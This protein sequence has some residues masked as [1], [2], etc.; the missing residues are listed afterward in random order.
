MT[1]VCLLVVLAV[2]LGFSFA[3]SPR[4]EVMLNRPDIVGLT[5]G[6]NTK[7]DGVVTTGLSVGTIVL[8]YDE[9]SGET[10]IYRLSDTTG[11]VSDSIP[12]VIVPDDYNA[13]T[14][15]KV[16]KLSISSDAGGTGS[17]DTIS[18]GSGDTTDTIVVA[19]QLKIYGE[20]IAD[21]IQAVG[22]TILVTDNMLISGGNRYY[23]VD[24]TGADSFWIYDDG[25]T[26]RFDSDNPI[27]V[28]HSSLVVDTTGDVDIDGD[29]DI[30]GDIDVD[31]TS[32]FGGDVNI[33][34]NLTVTGHIIETGSKISVD[35]VLSGDKDITTDTLVLYDQF[36]VYG[37]LIADSIQAV[38][39]TIL[40]TDNMLISGGNRYYGVDATGADSFWI[41]DDG[42]TTRFDSDN[43]IKIGHGSVVSGN[44]T[45]MSGN[46]FV[47]DTLIIGDVKEDST[48]DSILV[49]SSDGRVS[50]A[51]KS[52]FSGGAGGCIQNQYSS[53]QNAN[54]WISGRLSAAILRAVPNAPDTFTPQTG[55]IRT[56][57]NG[58][59]FR[60]YIYD[61][62]HWRMW[63]PVI[64]TS[65]CYGGTLSVDAGDDTTI[66]NG[67]S[68]SLTAVVSG[69]WAP[70][71]YDWDN[72]GTSDWDDPQTITVSPT[73]TTLYHIRVRDITS[74]VASDS[75]TVNVVPCCA[76]AIGG[77]NSD[78]GWSVVQT[79]DGGFVVAGYTR[80][81]GAGSS[82]LF[83]VKFNSS[84]SVQWAKAV[85]GTND[86]YGYSV[87]QTSDSGLVVAGYTESFGAGYD[88]LFLVKFN[89]SGSVQWAKAV[90][91]TGYDYGYSVVQTSDSGFVVAGYTY[92]FG[93]GSGDLFL[94]KF[95]SSGS[96]QWAKA[97]GGTGWDY[98]HSVI[99]T[100]DSGL[101]VV[102]LT[103][104]YGVLYHAI[105]CDLF[106]VKFNSSG[107]VQWAK[108]VGG[109]NLDFGE[110]VIETSDSGLVVAGYTGSYG[111]GGDNLFIVKFNSSGSVQWAKAVGGTSGDYGNSVIQTSD[112][113]FVV[114]GY[115]RSF[116]A[117][118][119][120]LFLVKFNS[121]GSMQW[122]K[123]VG[124]AND[125]EGYSV[126]QASNSGLVVS[127]Y[128]QSFGAGSSDLFL[129]KFGSDG[130]CCIGT[131]V[132]PTVTTVSPTVNSPSPSTATPTPTVTT[133]S[134]TVTNVSPT[135]TDCC[136]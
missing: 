95:N 22:N 78:K 83:L 88:D 127:G 41:Y 94:V 106:L 103:M 44:S 136:P 19:A 96:V 117:G 23:G 132:T 114:A 107:S 28:G 32:E 128:T 14:N 58:S 2:L 118:N 53:A 9:S 16:W 10:R 52:S 43:P 36:K 131:S 25:D 37:E 116:G 104:S 129:V 11:V 84:D 134:P 49:L 98:G 12:I 39:N 1:R 15:H 68:V 18:P 35:T 33:G 62:N 115:T 124:G 77:T 74:A 135:E 40:V 105:I 125:D 133:V 20:L 29:L 130:S 13:T 64:D 56:Y 46:A 120:D 99:Q 8:V 50:V 48:T 90:G 76:R 101:V 31:G 54:A 24:A 109:T 30:G 59:T 42:D 72:D 71:D 86:D 67:Q 82:D 4:Y 112:S 70:Y 6:G 66:Y 93:A 92:S 113:G 5:G 55:M 75:V 89:S 26:T 60:A 91:G 51:S 34:G 123:A 111:A 81:F 80:S 110:S 65:N 79:S 97:V 85:G 102:G 7:L 47:G 38:G 126:I 73:D 27:K 122:A 17:S 119:E 21:S 45:Y 87:I 100:S 108:A 63:F 57:G 3:Q 121:S 61:G 69:G